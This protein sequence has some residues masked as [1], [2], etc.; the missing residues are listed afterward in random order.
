MKSY[1]YLFL[2]VNCTVLGSE[3]ITAY[4][5]MD[6]GR[7]Q[8]TFQ[9]NTEDFVFLGDPKHFGL[10]VITKNG[11]RLLGDQPFGKKNTKLVLLYP[12]GKGHSNTESRYEVSFESKNLNKF[13][14]EK[15]KVVVW[16]CPLSKVINGKSVNM[17]RV[18]VELKD[19][20]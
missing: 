18:E 12:D 17:E 14:L 13:L 8:I 3:P 15:K 9:N 16:L 6:G 20:E 1:H 7:I 4:S 19:A 10:T 5:K 11:G 2:F